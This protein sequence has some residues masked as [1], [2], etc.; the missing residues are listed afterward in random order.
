M[1]EEKKRIKRPTQ[2]NQLF[3]F[4]TVYLFIICLVCYAYPVFAHTDFETPPILQAESILKPEIIKG[5]YHTVDDQVKNNGLFNHYTVETPFGKFNANSTRSLKQLVN[6]INAIAIMEKVETGDTAALA[7]KKS[8]ENVVS[9]M[10]NLFTDPEGALEGAASGIS[11]I[12]NRAKETIGKRETTNAEDSKVKQ[13]IGMS[14]AKGQIA[15]K[16]GVN[17]YSRNQ[18]LQE[19]LNRLGQADYLGGLGVGVATSFVPGVGGIVLSA[20]GAARLLQEAINTTPAS[21]LW[22]QNKNKLLEMMSDAD[23]VKL[24]LNNPVFSPDLQT[25][26]VAA[27][28]ALKGVANRELF[29]KVALQ[30]SDPDMAQTITAIAVMSAGYHKHIAPLK[31]FAPL[32][33]ITRALRA[34]GTF[35]VLL[36]T[37]Y[38]V[39]SE[40]I[41][42]ITKSLTNNQKKS[43]KAGL[44]LWTLGAISQRTQSELETMSWKI[45]TDAGSRLIPQK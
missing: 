43:E 19:E 1:S 31:S 30:A 45:H 29:V 36:P 7:V 9:G 35:V 37:D 24:F 15:N 26:L 10:K 28:K 32:A 17:V 27:L 44:E 41:A 39:W 22:V 8:G 20:S 4:V 38:I 11:S 23:T 5:E 40:K 18:R 16:Y 21:E 6:E 33:R 14:K 25:V 34:D 2:I 3:S 12:F 42:D 13:L